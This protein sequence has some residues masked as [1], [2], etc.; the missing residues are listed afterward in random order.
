M[1]ATD[2]EGLTATISVEINIEDIDEPIVAEAISI[3]DE[4]LA[5]AIRET[6][7][8]EIEAATTQPDM[9]Q[10]KSLSATNQEITD[11]TGLEFAIN[12]QNLVLTDNQ[13][14]DIYP[15]SGLTQLVELLLQGNQISDVTPL[16]ELINLERLVLVGNPITNKEPLLTLLRNN[17]DIKIYLKNDREPLPVTLSYFRAELTNTGVIL[18]W[19]TESEV[20]NAGFN[21]LRS[22]TRNGKFK[23][24]N[25]KLIEG[26][27]TTGERQKY[28]WTDTTAKPNTIYYYRIEDISHAGVRQQLATVRMRGLV[29]A[30]GKFATSWAGLKAQN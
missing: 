14:S 17:P 1:T 24:I 25:P 5:S 28:T 8:L 2:T 30:R 29:L 26:A 20:D 16:A 19:T 3:P 18:K 12:L 22:N 4:N 7:S 9:Q 27:G 23:I 10:L 15:L 11:L 13:I 6:L 21:I